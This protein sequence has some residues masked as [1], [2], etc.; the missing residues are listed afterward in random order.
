MCGLKSHRAQ[1]TIKPEPKGPVFHRDQGPQ[2]EPA[3]F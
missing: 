2:S 1:N 3:L